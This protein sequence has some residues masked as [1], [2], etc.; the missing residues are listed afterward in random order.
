MNPSNVL[1]NAALLP[2]IVTNCANE[3]FVYS[4]YRQDFEKSALEPKRFEKKRLL[5]DNCLT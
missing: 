3:L 2:K 1:A 5:A 4:F